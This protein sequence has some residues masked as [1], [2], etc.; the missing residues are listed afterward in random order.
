MASL[1]SL[2]TQ[3]KDSHLVERICPDKARDEQVGVYGFVF[4]RDGQWISEVIDDKLYLSQPDYDDWSG[5][6]R[7]AWDGSHRRM[8]PAQSREQYRQHHQTGP[9]ALYFSSCADQN[10]TWVPLI[11]KAFAKAHGDFS[12]IAGGRPG[13]GIED[14]TGGITTELCS[15]D[16][17]DKY[18]FWK[19]GLTKVNQ[20]FLFKGTTM[21][22][23]SPDY[24]NTGRQGIADGHACSVLRATE[25][26]GARLLLV[27]NP[28]GEVEWNGAWRDGCKK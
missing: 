21:V 7:L 17:L 26:E 24:T 5:S 20:D 23:D 2:C 6:D 19:E 10:E 1:V 9:D 15:N 8:S 22:Y 27:K 3:E 25:Y 16:I 12:A 11:E 13:K 28:W 14:L 18:L 4:F